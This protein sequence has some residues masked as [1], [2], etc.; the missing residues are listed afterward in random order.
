M[1][2]RKTTTF[3]L[4][5]SAVLVWGIIAVRMIRWIRIGNDEVQ[6][7]CTVKPHV[8][9]PVPEPPAMEYQDPFLKEIRWK[10][11]VPETERQGQDTGA[12]EET[13]PPHIV[14]KG[15]IKCSGIP[16]AIVMDSD[17]SVMLR[18]GDIFAGFS[19]TGFSYDEL[20]LERNGRTYR[21]QIE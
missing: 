11:P 4:A 21:L 6:T 20:V 7:V 16:V 5:V 15:L 19:V 10:S 2:T 12:P 9:D 18:H 8:G 17:C 1:K 3:V 14:F 13:P